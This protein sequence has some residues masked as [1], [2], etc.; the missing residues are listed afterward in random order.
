MPVVQLVVQSVV[1]ASVVSGGVVRVLV[2]LEGVHVDQAGLGQ[3]RDDVAGLEDREAAVGGQVGHGALTVDLAEHRPLARAE[4]D[5]GVSGTRGGQHGDGVGP[6]DLAGQPLPVGGADAQALEQVGYA[7]RRGDVLPG[8]LRLAEA[9]GVGLPGQ[10]VDE[11]VDEL[12]ADEGL[13]H[14]AVDVPEVDEQ[15][16]EPPALQLG[17]LDLQRLGERLGRQ[18][19]GGRQ[20]GA[21]QGSPAGHEDGIDQAV[22][23]IDLGLFVGAAGDVQAAGRPLSPQVKQDLLNR[24]GEKVAVEHAGG[25]PPLGSVG[26][27]HHRHVPPVC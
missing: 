20:P 16:T 22:P 14:V 13:D 7:L 21:E 24:T 8:L 2:V 10:Q 17:A 3:G 1:Q 4:D 9:P 5:V 11:H 23:Q 6:A 27:F 15:L 19:A 12:L 26:T 18:L 25:P